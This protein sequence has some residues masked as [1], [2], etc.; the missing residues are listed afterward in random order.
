MTTQEPASF[1]ERD[2]EESEQ[3]DLGEQSVQGVPQPA[4]QARTGQ[5]TWP[6]PTV[7]TLQDL[8][9]LPM[10]IL[11]AETY[12]HLQNA[13]RE[14]ALTFYSLWRNLSKTLGEDSGQKVRKRIDIE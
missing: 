9:D 2:R 3:G 4:E 13:T 11:P 1:E 8:I 14:T 6:Q 10:Q 12:M 7:L 5:Q